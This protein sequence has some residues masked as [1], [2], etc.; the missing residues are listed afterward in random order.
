MNRILQKIIFAA[1]AA[2]LCGCM[3]GPDFEKPKANLPE[4]WN[5]QDSG[6]KL[7]E[8]DTA[9]KLSEKELVEWWAIFNDPVLTSL[10]GRAFEGNL[11]IADAK[12]VIDQA[13]ATLG[14]T[15]SG[16]F[17]SLDANADMAEGTN[18]MAAVEHA[19]YGMGASASWELDVFG[20]T[21]RAIESSVEDYRAA[22]ADKCAV[23]IA[24]AAE[25]AQ[26]YFL[27]RAYQQILV[28]TKSN[29]ETQKKTYSITLRRKQNGFVSQLDVVRASAAVQSTSSEIPSIESKMVLA[30]HSLE[31]LLGLPAGSLEKELSQPKDLP[32]LEN[33]MPIGV[34]AKLVERRPDIIV[35]EHQ[36]HSAVA[37]IGNAEADLYPKFYVTGNISYEAPS[38]GSLVQK[39]YGS[40]SVGPSATWSIFQ[41]GK[42][43]YNIDLQ[44][45][46]SDAAKV[47]WQK[48]VLTAFKEVEDALVSS[49]KERERIEF[50]NV[51]V[52]DNRKAF[53]LSTRLYAEGEIEFLD[54]LDTQRSM[55]TSEQN[56]VESRRLFVTNIVSLYKALGGGW[57]PEDMKDSAPEKTRWLFFKNSFNDAD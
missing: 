32:E 37:S 48:T 44:K 49:S 16:L 4:G 14:M 54:L 25:V 56:Q 11:D 10:V 40:W 33:F 35:A 46:V 41:A 17:P 24:V 52:S 26:N 28:I 53:E 39:Q 12:A 57:S 9:R 18:S 27:Y 50:I 19:S 55:L 7:T 51:L 8:A 2:A 20:G 47:S 45:A 31:L 23:R 34:P 3:V 13:R 1:S 43:V 15:Q 5:L 38:V 6:K 21:R 29:L 30:R 22:L 42:I 36:L